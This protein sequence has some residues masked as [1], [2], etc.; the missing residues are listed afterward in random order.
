MTYSVDAS[1][2]ENFHKRATEDYSQY[3]QHLRACAQFVF[4]A[5]GGAALAVLSCLTAVSTAKDLNQA[6]RVS[7][8]LPR[9]AGAVSCYLGG[10][11]L[12]VLALCAFTVS[13]QSWGH[14]WEDNAIEG[15]VDFRKAFAQRGELF[16]KAGFFLLMLAIA[17]FVPGS[18]M[19]VIAFLS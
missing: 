13:Q 5:N 7:T 14:F 2:K 18:F 17:A 4:A 11:F 6:I 9:F 10:V 8:I 15:Q 1:I 3:S 16:T 19:A 12:A